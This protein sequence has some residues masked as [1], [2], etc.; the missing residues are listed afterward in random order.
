MPKSL[1]LG[2]GTIL[3]GLDHYGQVRDFYFPY[4]GLE[5]HVGGHFVHRIGVW[6][7]GRVSWLGDGSW[8]IK[9]NCEKDTFASNIKAVNQ[10]IKVGIDFCDV[11]YNEK[12]IFV[13]KATLRNLENREREIKLFFG[14][15]FELY[16]SHRGDTAYYDPKRKAII[17]YKGRRIFLVNARAGGKEFDSYNIGLFGIEG[18]EGSFK[19]AEDGI[20]SQNPIEHG[21]VD[22]V[23]GFSFPVESRGSRVIYYWITAAKL[24]EE[25]CSLNEY[26]LSKSPSYLMESS[27]SFWRAWIN[28]QHFDFVG[29]DDE[30]IEL[31]KKSLFVIRAHAD[32]TSG[33]IIASSDSDMLQYGRDTYSYMWPRDGAFTAIALDKVG[34]DHVAE[35][36]FEFCNAVISEEGYLLHKYRSDRSLGSSWHPWVR[37]G[38]PTL[39]IQEDETALVLYALWKHY[40]ISR[41]LEFIETLYN[42]LI[43]KAAGFMVEYRD[44]KTKLPKPSYDLWEEKFGTSTFTA[45]AVY[46]ALVAAS[47]FAKLLGK[48]ESEATYDSAA[49]EVKKGILAHLYSK[50]EGIFY[51]MLW[52]ENGEMHHDKTIDM[53]SIYGVWRFGVLPL[54]DERIKRAMQ[55]VQERLCC[56]T[57]IKGVPRYEGDQYYNVSSEIPGN[58]WFITTLWLAQYE[59][60]R[61]RTEKELDGV[62][63][64][65]SW[66]ATY[67]LPSGILS[68]QLHPFTGEQ[69]SAAPLTWSHAEFVLTV[70]EY[71]EKLEELGICKTCNPIRVIH[72]V[73]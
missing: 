20:L 16:G 73:Q 62:K 65:L 10:D 4:V 61:A 2:N 53:S 5:N 51:K 14:Q 43:K 59:L 30:V 31:F 56:K 55:V 17:H 22:S 33:S 26:V 46:G 72:E 45:S 50:E 27:K 38:E 70:V 15:E 57:S 3:V 18:K 39:P 58:P 29:L 8:N 24:I 36:F 60:A 6:V 11:V 67:A 34:D 68:E 71:L 44:E 40:E 32:S 7:E 35:R 63:K 66:A 64:W 69:L 12:N 28:K 41:D 25:T 9:V 37:G 13:R 47:K 48:G 1:T 42:S 52:R 54:D 21:Q 19:D 23:I 49:A